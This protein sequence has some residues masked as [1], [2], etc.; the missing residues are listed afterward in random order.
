[1]LKVVYVKSWGSSEFYGDFEQQ[2]KD[3]ESK[4]QWCMTPDQL[5]EKASLMHCL[6][7]RR[8]LVVSDEVLDSDQSVVIDQAEN[9]LW[10]QMAIMEKVFSN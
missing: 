3:F 4:T 10:A 6:P 5:G 8:N 7:V 2:A 1:M 9:R